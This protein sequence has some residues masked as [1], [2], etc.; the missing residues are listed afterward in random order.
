MLTDAEK[1]I[2]KKLKEVKKLRQESTAL[3]EVQKTYGQTKKSNQ[4]ITDLLFARCILM[5]EIQQLEN[6]I[7]PGHQNVN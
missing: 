1:L 2:E 3:L 5:Q 7:H 4:Q 6:I